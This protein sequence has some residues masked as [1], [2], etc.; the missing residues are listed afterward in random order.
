MLLNVYQPAGA[1]NVPGFG[2]Y[3]SGIVL[4]DTEYTFAGGES[5]L[6][7]VYSHRPRQQPPEGPDGSRWQFK[8]TVD[9]G[10]CDYPKPEIKEMVNSLSKNFK[11]NTYHI[12]SRNCNHF[13]EALCHLLGVPFPAWVNRLANV[14]DNFKGLLAAP[15]AAAAAPPVNAEVA[16]KVEA[17]VN[18]MTCV[19]TASA[20]C[21][22]ESSDYPLSSFLK[23]K[24]FLQSD[25]DAQLLIFLPFS[26]PVKLMAVVLK[27]LP[28][29]G[30]SQCPKKIK[31]W[32][33]KPNM[34]F[35]DTV[36][37]CTEEL[38]I[39]AAD[40]A[41]PVQSGLITILKPV[42]FVKFLDVSYLTIF[43]E[44]NYG[45]RDTTR[46]QG[47][48]LPGQSRAQAGFKGVAKPVNK[49]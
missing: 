17:T 1:N 39:T 26:G 36:V 2:V 35:E 29:E 16:T 47:L 21:L 31:L 20:G 42:T 30:V 23:Q 38:E 43:V 33:N 5:S 45:N 11:A 18:L 10:A 19:E 44:S 49:A 8:E 3:H 40:L 9:L 41:A 48:E 13:S 27:V 15:S 34:D 37:E 25:A 22:N 14:G 6:T 46:I 12:T 32:K 24:S 4:Y 28:G 7:G